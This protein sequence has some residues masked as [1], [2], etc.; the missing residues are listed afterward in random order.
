MK[1]TMIRQGDVLLIPVLK[2]D[3]RLARTA[4]EPENGRVILA[5]GEATGHHHSL[6]A[7]V[8]NLTERD[9]KRYL[10]VLADSPLE[11]Q[12]HDPI[13]VPKGTYLVVR[14]V[15]YAPEAIRNVQD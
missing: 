2:R 4:I 3:M 15:E 5:Y 8:A 10:R 11:H 12:E 1:P 13:L 14:Q 9:G 6:S 7:K